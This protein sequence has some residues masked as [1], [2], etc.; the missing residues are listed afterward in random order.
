[1]NWSTIHDKLTME[2]GVKE[3]SSRTYNIKSTWAGVET[4]QTHWY[5]MNLVCESWLCRVPNTKDLDRHMKERISFIELA[6]REREDGLKTINAKLPML[7]AVAEMTDKRPRTITNL[8]GSRVAAVN[9][10]NAK[11]ND[12][13]RQS[14]HELNVRFEQARTPLNY[15]N[16]FIQITTDALTQK[17]IDQPFW[18][19][20]K[21]PKWVNVDIDMKE[22]VDRRDTAGR[23]PAFYAAKALESTIKII[24]K[25]KA[26]ETGNEKGASDWLNHL[27]KK[28]NGP[29]VAS[30]ERELMQRFFGGVRNEFGHGPG[31]EKMPELTEAQTDYA[32]EFC[33]SWTKSLIKRL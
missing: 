18:A 11:L 5:N 14:V 15:H 26:W 30:W 33:M 12:A 27:E 17:Q 16:G 32:I 4:H 28:A 19:L 8:P 25:E 22:A 7:L 31:G 24:C 3:L 10:G 2:L 21:D 23:D 29:F 20:V 6:F 13:F 1:M 9:E